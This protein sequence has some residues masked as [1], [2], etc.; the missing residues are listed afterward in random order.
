[1][2]QL[3]APNVALLQPRPTRLDQTQSSQTH[4]QG[5][6]DVLIV[7]AGLSGIGFAWHLQ[8]HCP[9]KSFAILEARDAIGGTWDLFRYPG[10]RSDSDMHTLG[11]HFKP[12]R[13][14]KSIADGP[15]ILTYLQQTAAEHGIDHKIRFGHKVTRASWSSAQARWTVEVTGPDGTAHQWTCNFLQMCSGYYDYD[16]G[17]MPGWPGMDRFKGKILHPQ[18]WPDDLDYAGARVV[19]IGSGATAVTLVPAMTDRASRVTML[20]RSPT[21]VVARPGKD[22]LANWMYQKLPEGIAHSLARWKNIL[23]QMYFYRAARRDPERAKQAIIGRAQAALGPDVDVGKHFTPRYHPWDQRLCLVPDGDLFK[24]IRDGKASVVT[25]EIETFTETGIKLRSGA[26]LAA[27]IIVTATGLKVKLMGGAQIVVDGAPADLGNTMNY[28]GVMYNDIP[29]LGSTFGY[30]N[31]S[32][33]L[34]ADLTAEYL[35]RL[36]NHM[37]RRGYAAATPPQHRPHGHARCDD[38]AKLRISRA[39][40]GHLAE[41]RHEGAME[42]AP[43]LRSRSDGTAFRSRR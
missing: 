4:P 34:K 15:S 14:E 16:G 38:A 29:N 17:Y 8:K 21:Y 24:A 43:E 22:A 3:N 31:A 20:Q 26:E 7:G 40:E 9:H 6:L 25:D 11:F 36:L 1:M 32:W 12:W 33:T 10:I 5:H 41:A 2:D 27:D 30:T 37:E 13:G 42:T 23:L 28:K 35:C 19:V 18:A 39:S